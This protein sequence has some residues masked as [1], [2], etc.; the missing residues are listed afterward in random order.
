[1]K[2]EKKLLL[3][4][5]DISIL[6]LSLYLTLFLRYLRFPGQEVWQLHFWVFSFVFVAWVIIFYI[7]DLYNLNLAVNNEK[8]FRKSLKAILIADL[9]SASFFYIN[10]H[11]G[12]APKTN[13]IIYLF[14]FAILFF[15]WRRT[16][17]WLLHARIPRLNLAFVGYNNQAK[18]L[19][20]K[21][22]E[23]P[24]LGYRVALIISGHTSEFIDN[25]PVQRSI[26]KIKDS[27]K[28]HGINSIILASD[29][30]HSEELR[31]A[32]F[33]CLPLKINFQNLSDFYEQITG[34]IP[35]EAIGESWF[36]ENLSEGSKRTYDFIKRSYDIIIALAILI[37]TAYFWPLIG[38]LLKIENKEPIFFTQIRA[39]KDGRN[40]RMLKFRTQRT[41]S[42]NPEPAQKNDQRTT[43]VGSFLR[44]TRIDEIP[45]VI[46][47]LLGDMSFI[48]PRPERPEIIASLEKEVPFYNERLLVKPGLTGW[49]Q[50]SGEYHSPSRE[51]TL[52]KLQYDLY[53]IKNRSL[54]LDATII[55]K[56][57][58]TI[59]SRAGV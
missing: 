45:Q 47:I 20:H 34:R 48:G 6:Y 56:T 13:L 59:F 50:V 3:L 17:N 5:G 23:T 7:S 16:F 10:P 39:G 55:L 41:L 44:K 37:V 18:E 26:P 36:L 29:L 21:L 25:I 4:I 57:I 19:I 43:N 2:R 30:S 33:S 58:A 27:L 9:L 14:V 32:L 38:I 31:S 52:K 22:E 15:L 51:D 11:I 42:E 35:I 46:N 24:H 49:D 12:I 40:F 8:F 53:Y 1:M 54:F 28:K